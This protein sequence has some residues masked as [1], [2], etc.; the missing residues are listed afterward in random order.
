MSRPPFSL[1]SLFLCHDLKI[2]V[3]TSKHLCIL[4]YVATLT[5]LI[6]TKL[7][8]P[9]STLCRD[10]VFLS[11]PKLLLQHLFCLNKHFH[12]AEVSVVTDEGPVATDI[13]PLVHHYVATQTILFPT[14]LHMFFPFSVTT[15]C[16]L[17]QPSSIVNNQIMVLRHKKCC[18]DTIYL[19]IA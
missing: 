10:L 4:K 1:F 15:C 14:D 6:A 17:S 18:C 16:L 12:V 2:S 11:H 7:V 5:L 13:L 3:A 8:H 9:L 19:V